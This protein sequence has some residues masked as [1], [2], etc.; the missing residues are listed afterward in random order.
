[1]DLLADSILA[2]EALFA[3]LIFA[4]R[5]VEIDVPFV[6]VTGAR[7]QRCQFGHELSPCVYLSFRCTSVPPAGIG[8]S[9]V[10]PSVE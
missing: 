9:A 7:I 5:L 3:Y 10:N 2:R 6:D 8:A 1:M 4:L